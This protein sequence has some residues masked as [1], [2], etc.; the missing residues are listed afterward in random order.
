MPIISIESGNVRIVLKA[1]L[2]MEQ[3]K[4]Y[5]NMGA[6]D[7]MEIVIN[8]IETST[9]TLSMVSIIVKIAQETVD[10]MGLIKAVENIDK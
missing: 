7:N 10:V 9:L 2:V 4:N 3:I 5:A 8:V 6:L 1:T